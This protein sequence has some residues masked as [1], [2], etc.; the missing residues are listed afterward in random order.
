MTIESRKKMSETANEIC[1]L[2]AVVV[3]VVVVVVVG[4][5]VHFFEVLHNNSTNKVHFVSFHSSFH[6]HI[7]HRH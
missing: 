3:V 6:I 5:V 1:S 7:K 2:L 4:A